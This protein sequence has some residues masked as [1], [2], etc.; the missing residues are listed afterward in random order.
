MASAI[1]IQ[2][3]GKGQVLQGLNVVQLDGSFWMKLRICH[4]S[5][6]GVILYSMLQH[7]MQAK[8]SFAWKVIY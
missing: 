3:H 5:K 2:V 1:D 4:A 8:R 6:M 7:L